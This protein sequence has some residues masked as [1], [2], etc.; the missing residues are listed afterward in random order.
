MKS[1][2]DWM[3]K[4]KGYVKFLDEEIRN[5][6][7]YEGFER[8]IDSEDFIRGLMAAEHKGEHIDRVRNRNYARNEAIN[9]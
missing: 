6:N 4:D 1:R 5:Y 2:P 7:D 3:N 8:A 9:K